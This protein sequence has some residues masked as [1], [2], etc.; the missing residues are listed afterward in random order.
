MNGLASPKV[1]RV[2]LN[3]EQALDFMQRKNIDVPE[4]VPNGW[5]IFTYNGTNIGLA[6]NLGS[7]INN[8]Y[9]ADWRIRKEPSAAWEAENY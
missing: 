7:R 3:L 4:N 2:P 6:K 9:P 5:I 1:P 8:H